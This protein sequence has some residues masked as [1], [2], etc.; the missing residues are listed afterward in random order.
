MSAK[1]GA[2]SDAK[3]PKSDTDAL[4]KFRKWLWGVYVS[5]VNEMLEWLAT[6]GDSNVQIGALRTLM[7][8]V[9]REGEM[10][11]GGGASFGNET[12]MRVVQQLL[13]APKLKGELASVFKGEYV[14]A[15]IDV[16]YYLVGLLAKILDAYCSRC[17]C[18]LMLSLSLRLDHS[19]RT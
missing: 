15:Y 9:A 8:F 10:R 7:E 17:N 12:F 14:G 13:A 3:K 5:F 1:E 16:Q 11:A 18:A 2:A 19:S 6:K 4:G